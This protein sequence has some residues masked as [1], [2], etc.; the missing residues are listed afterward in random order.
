MALSLQPWCSVGDK[1]HARQLMECETACT[2]QGR[3]RP[4][5]QVT[6]SAGG[7]VVNTAGTF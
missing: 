6:I 2:F 4:E 3:E 1:E 5:H 7:Q